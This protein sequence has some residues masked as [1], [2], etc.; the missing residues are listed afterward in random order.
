M[1][2]MPTIQLELDL[3]FSMCGSMKLSLKVKRVK[4]SFGK[5][6][7]QAKFTFKLVSTHK[8]LIKRTLTTLSNYTRNTY[9]WINYL[10][11]V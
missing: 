3:D 2:A 11:Q 10:L 7:K 9:K 1:L 4:C 8:G 6:P 5:A